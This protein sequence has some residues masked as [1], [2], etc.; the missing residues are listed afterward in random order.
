M[1]QQDIESST[2]NLPIDCTNGILIPDSPVN[3]ELDVTKSD[4]SLNPP[5]ISHISVE[6]Y[7]VIAPLQSNKLTASNI[8]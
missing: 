6:N 4:L 2:Y 1:L 7:E 3:S 5:E 8:F